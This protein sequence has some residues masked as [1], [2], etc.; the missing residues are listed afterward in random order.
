MREL[1]SVSDSN[2]AIQVN[3]RHGIESLGSWYRCS[4]SNRGPG[5]VKPSDI[6]FLAL[7]DSKMKRSGENAAH[8]TVHLLKRVGRTGLRN[9]Q[10]QI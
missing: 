8:L 3:K 7:S 6:T 10:H 5:I 9:L 1:N 2:P 4:L